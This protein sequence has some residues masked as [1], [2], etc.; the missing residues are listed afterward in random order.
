MI[1]CLKMEYYTKMKVWFYHQNIG[2]ELWKY[3][4]KDILKAMKGKA[5]FQAQWPRINSEDFVKRCVKCQEN[6]VPLFLWT[7]SSYGKE[8]TL[9]SIA[10]FGENSRYKKWLKVL[11]TNGTANKR[12]MNISILRSILKLQGTMVHNSNHM[13]SRHTAKVSIINMHASLIPS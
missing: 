4:M 7:M 9:I 11:P 12:S 13:N 10:F 8:F 5:R 3:Y 1:F 6:E 2:V